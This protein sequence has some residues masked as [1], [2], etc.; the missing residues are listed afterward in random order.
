MA[1]D[2]HW[3]LFGARKALRLVA[4]H[5]DTVI[6]NVLVISCHW[7]Q[8]TTQP[9]HGIICIY[10]KF[11]FKRNM[12]QD[13]FAKIANELSVR[14]EQVQAVFRLLSEDATVPFIA[15][16]RKEATDS[17][18]EVAIASIRDRLDE[19]AELDE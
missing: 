17:L 8:C 13:H 15:R 1:V 6:T 19:L 4:Q 5:R 10:R 9:L 18:D 2:Y 7:I 3:R 16:Y 11:S 14:A 12:S